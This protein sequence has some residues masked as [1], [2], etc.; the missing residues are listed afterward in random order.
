MQHLP[1][2]C[3]GQRGIWRI[4]RRK[5]I[6]SATPKARWMRVTF[7]QKSNLRRS[8]LSMRYFLPLDGDFWPDEKASEV[9]FTT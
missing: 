8:G 3:E 2:D 9:W 7:G 6:R 4:T 5:K 1:E